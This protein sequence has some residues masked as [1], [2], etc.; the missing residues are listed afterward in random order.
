MIASRREVLIGLAALAACAPTA[1]PGR[2]VFAAGQPAAI[3]IFMLASDRLLGWP[4]RPNS[5]P[6]A[7]LPASADLPQLGALTSGG[8][9]ANLEAVVAMKQRL[10][11]DYGDVDSNYRDIT[12]RV[13]RRLSVPN[14]LID[15]ALRPT[16]E[17]LVDA[18]AAFQIIFRNPLVAPDL[19]GVSSRAGLG[20]AAA[21]LAGAAPMLIQLG[22]FAGGLGA[23][24]L[25]LTCARLARGADPRLTLVLCGIVT[26]A[27]A[28]AGLALAIVI[29][30]PYEQLPAI[31]FWL[32]GSFARTEFG[33]VIAAAG[34]AAVGLLLL[35]SR[36]G[37]RLYVLSLGDNQARALGLPARA[38]P[39][40]AIAGATLATSAAVAVAGVVGWIG[41]LAPHAARLLVGSRANLLLPASFGI[42]AL[43]ALSIDRLSVTFGPAEVPVGVLASAA[44]APIFPLLFVVTSR[45]SW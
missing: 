35:L 37:F 14:R 17:A 10:V 9:P 32:L 41:L 23:A 21:A 38:L 12:A 4:R 36:L 45:R 39:L 18:G 3:L 7:F 11:V 31:T 25:A 8:A 20:A 22:A 44:G 1:K 42:G 15:G 43:F 29:A 33:D 13:E 2:D 40:A 26:G 28:S 24:A 6:L 34:T 30:D 27:L 5:Q 19:L 16:P